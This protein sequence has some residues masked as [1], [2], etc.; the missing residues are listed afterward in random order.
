MMG[1][2]A[3]VKKERMGIMLELSRESAGKFHSGFINKAEAV[4]WE[5][6]SDTGVWN[7]YTSN[8]IRV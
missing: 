4:L 1:I 6:K 7:G 3:A 2:D 8:Y 5:Q